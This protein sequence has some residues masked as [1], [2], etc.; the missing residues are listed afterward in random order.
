MFALPIKSTHSLHQLTVLLPA[1]GQLLP[2]HAADVVTVLHGLHLVPT[3][4]A[5]REAHRLLRPQGL[6]V[7]A[8]NDRDQSSPF[9]RDLEG[10]MEGFNADYSRHLKQRD[11]NHWGDVLQQGGLFRLLEYSVHPNPLPLRGAAPLLDIL[12]CLTFMRH[13]RRPSAERRALHGRV[14]DLVHRYARQ[15]LNDTKRLTTAIK[16]AFW[17]GGVCAAARDQAV[18]V[19]AGGWRR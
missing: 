7:A 18:S 19:A 12:D 13:S 8:W 11:L 6:L 2:A 15:R 16:Q 4:A 5:L 14:M 9:I 10:L 1:Q 17:Q 3:A